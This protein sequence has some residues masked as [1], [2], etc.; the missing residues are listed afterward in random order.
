M[1][2]TKYPPSLDFLLMTLGPALIL[3]GL[4][5]GFHL[6]RLRPAIVFGRVPLFYYVVHV[7]LIHLAAV[8][9]CYWKFGGAHW[10]FQSTTIADFPATRPPGWGFRL[11][12]VYLIWIALIAALYPLCRWF[13]ERKRRG[14]G[15]FRSYL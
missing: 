10:L 11:L 14:G 3:P 15:W 5:D 1:N 7:P 9:I 12:V 6:R 13:L 2:C 8:A 4:L